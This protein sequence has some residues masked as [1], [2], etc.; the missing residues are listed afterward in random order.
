MI[1]E[2]S[3]QFGLG[4]LL[5]G[6]IFFLL[7]WGISRLISRLRPS[8][9]PSD[10]STTSPDLDG[11]D[12]AVLVL[13]AGGRVE[14]ANQAARDWFGLREG[15]PPNLELIARNIRP[16]GKFLEL[17]VEEGGDRFSLTGRPIDVTSYRVPGPVPVMMVTLHRPDALASSAE[18]T[19]GSGSMLKLLTDFSQAI[20]TSHGLKV[21]LQA[22]MDNVEKLVPADY[23]EIKIWEPDSQT[24]LPYR[25]LSGAGGERYLEKGLPQSLAGYSSQLYQSQQPIFIPHIE[26]SNDKPIAADVWSGVRSF[27][28]MPLLVEDRFIGTLEIGLTAADAYVKENLDVLRLV[29]GQM[30]IAIRNSA[31]YD[32]QQQRSA[33]LSGLANLAHAIGSTRDQRDLFSQLVESVE[34]LFDADVI[35]FL[36]FNESRRTLEAQVP[37]VGMPAPFVE[38]YRLPIQSGSALEKHL[39]SLRILQTHNAQED[40]VWGEMGLQDFAR[41]ASWRDVA[42]VPLVSSGRPL[43]YLQVAN[44]QDPDEAF[45]ADEMRLFNIVVNQAAPIIENVSL[46]HQARQRAQRSEALRRIANLTSSTATLDE[47]LRFSIQ[48]LG[49]LFQA[50]ISGVFLLDEPSGALELHLPSLFGI[51]AEA[52]IPVER[53]FAPESQAHFTVT[54][55]QKAYIS[56]NLS[57]DPNLLEVY[58]GLVDTLDIVSAVAVPLVVREQ[59]LGELWIASQRQDFFTSYDLQI[60]STA[61]GQLAA[62]IE[63][64]ALSVQTDEKLRRRVDQ[65]SAL[66]RV[67]RELSTTLEWEPLLQI[68]YGE[69]MKMTQADCGTVLFFTPDPENP[70][71]HK[72]HFHLGDEPGKNLRPIE[73][74]VLKK[75]KAQIVDDFSKSKY[76]PSHDDILSAMVVP[77]A[78]QDKVVGLLHLHSR[79]VAAFDDVALDVIQTLAVQA[80]IAIANAQEYQE[81]YKSNQQLGRKAEILSKL[82]EKSSALSLKQPLEQSLEQLAEGIQESTPFQIVL[83]SVIDPETMMQQRVAGSG[84]PADTLNMLKSRQQPWAAVAQLFRPEFMVGQG[85]FV[86]YEKRPVLSGDVQLVTLLTEQTVKE[87]HAWH[88]EDALLYPLFDSEGRPVGLISLDAPKDGMRPDEITLE[89]VEV[90]IAQASLLIQS[91]RQLANYQQQVKTLKT[92]LDQ[93]QHLFSVSQSHL[94]VLLHKDLEQTMSIRNIER[95]A[96]RIRAGLEITEVINRQVDGSSALLS[97]GREI[98]TRLEMSISLVAENTAEGQ[99]L[100]HVLGNIP[101]GISPEALF[102]QRNPLRYVLQTGET[103]LVMNLDEDEAWRDAPLLTS[104][105]ARGFI[106]LPV[107]VNEKPVAGVLAINLEPLPALTDEDRQVYLQISRQVSIILQNLGLLTETRRRL[108]EVNLLLDFSRQLSGLGPESI[109]QSLL[110]S[111]LRV[112]QAAHAGAVLLWN[113]Q[114]DCLTARAAANY[115]DTD[116]LM[117]ITYRPGEALPGQVFEQKLPRR[118]DEVSFARDYNLPAESLLLYREATSGRLPV[119]SLLVPIQTTIRTIG[120]LVLDNFN[121]PAAFSPDDEALLLSLTQQVALSLENVR[122]VEVS[123]ERATQLQALT[124][125][126][127]GMTMSLQSSELVAALLDRLQEMLHYDTSILWLRDANRMSVASARGFPDDEERIGLEVAIE[128]SSLMAEMIKTMESIVVGDVRT[129][130]RFLALTEAERLSWMGVPLV[131][132]GEVIGVIALEK[133]EPNFYTLE[134]SQLAITFASQAAIALE[135]AR[136]YEDSLR[137][138]AELDQRSQ[139]LALLNRLSDR[140]SGSLNEDQVLRLTAEEVQS[141]LAPTCVTVVSFDHFDTPSVRVRIPDTGDALAEL[142]D[143]PLFERLRESLGIFNSE[144]IARETDLAPLSEFLRDTKSLLVLPLASGQN[145]RAL[146]FIHMGE[147]YRFPATEIEL[148]RT[149]CNQAAVALENARLYQ[150]T[151]SRAEQ[152][153]TLN[154]ASYEIGLSLDPEEIY[155][156]I[157]RAVSEMMPAESFVISLLN[158]ERK[159]IEGVYLMDPSGRSPSMTLPLSEGLSGRVI[160]SGEPLLIPDVEE[161]ERMGGRTYGDGQPRSIVAVPIMMGGKVSG[162]L[163]AQSYQPNIYTEEEQQILSTLAN[164]A[165]VAIQNGRLYAETRR[166]AEELEQ[167]VIERTAELAREQRNTETLLRILTEVSSSLDLD[168]ALNRTLSLLNEAIGAEQGSIMMVN[169]DDNTINYR[170]GYGYVTPMMTEGVRPTALK[171]GEGLVGWI[172]KNRQ[173]VLLDDLRNDDR[174]VKLPFNTPQHRSVIGA[175]LMVGEEV[176]GSIMVFHRQV[177]YFT[178]DHMGLVQAIGSQVAVAINNAQLY[179][180]IRDQAERLGSYLRAQQ[181]EASRQKAILEA[182]ADGVVVT[183]P[184]NKINFVNPSAVQIL[185]LKVDDV[186]GESLERFV[187]IFGPA[188]QTWMQTIHTWSLDPTIYQVGDTYAEQLSLETGKVV[189]VHL[190]PVIWRN[191]FLGTVSI[192]RDIT[193]EVEVDRLKSEFVATVSHE[194]RTPMTSIKGYVDVLLM[195]AAGAMNESQTHF[196]DIVRSNTDR[197]SVL[198]NDLLDVSRIEAGRVSLTMESLNLS[199]IA[200]DAMADVLRRSQEENKPMDIALDA[201][202]DLP[203]VCGD[204]ERVRQILGNL[205]DNAYHYTPANGKIVIQIGVNGEEVQVEIKDNGI[206]VDPIHHGMIFERFYRG[207]D[208][209][210]LGTPGTGLGLSIVKQL[211]EMHHGQI[212]MDSPGIP[213]EGSV[214]SFT[215]P[216][217]REEE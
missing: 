189:L 191:E 175:P 109:L 6:V 32:K 134:Y 133:S 50:D 146:V 118:V 54:G 180:L 93:Q 198:V 28:G 122:L 139:R 152:L 41:A 35:G 56:G 162:M 34:P 200:Q 204:L 119:S 136:L 155:T 84:I 98:L 30:A 38:L 26:S 126:S 171:I 163:S 190:A 63:G 132:K 159:E 187:G 181:V 80:A 77:I 178:P 149:I 217:Y 144:E 99:R 81:Q 85:Y 165:A 214:F 39:L 16:G 95:R 45:S 65:F 140:L 125:A 101:R 102:G 188:A 153:T 169:Q 97:L 83:I 51:P 67:S 157:H 20:F 72:V 110:D 170:A 207:E 150:S 58:R 202:K 195:G 212:W 215:L 70:A 90:F 107:I 3:V 14:Y 117:Q 2:V 147:A 158:E 112:V 123:Q 5:T 29:T 48:E 201:P 113:D 143:A 111:A 103:L 154:R 13:H 94:P 209:L 62:A 116:S 12:H 22:V 74:D 114:E 66:T 33:E 115:A 129:D 206:G 164:Q 176:I 108:R 73:R 151:V 46:V 76:K 53:I 49:R 92:N 173:A 104:L 184:D 168:R 23:M 79:A 68:V 128:D 1:G 52:A 61:A 148:G 60:A 120:V 161:V 17:C 179:E 7:V 213:G 210:V 156:A 43:G 75:N 106:C 64:Q 89:S 196:L 100:V 87:P 141:A 216:V 11:H 47:I 96:R 174:W 160:S 183:D 199:E 167:R 186:I 105:R 130:P 69:S 193:H 203:P 86:P 205:V 194:L 57:E 137:R 82:F 9:L 19:D 121:T 25:Y 36:I 4:I 124:D 208:P 142:P 192:F 197:L 10:Q 127:A 88:P 145:L 91:G 31:E 37:F 59:G 166:L 18:P 44:H 71:Q 211:V 78:Y 8:S 42:L 182:V 27:I 138:A 15:E 24:L 40:E 131:I 135:N 177:G 172:I 21:S 55:S 185:D